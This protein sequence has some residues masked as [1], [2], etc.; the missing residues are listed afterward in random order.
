MSFFNFLF[1]KKK[2]TFKDESLNVVLS[3]AKAKQL[4]KRLVVLSHP[5][6]NPDNQELAT[7]LSSLV[8]Q[9]RYNYQALI[10]LE[11]RIVTEL[12]NK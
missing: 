2:K 9:N 6:R 7:E 12:L 1:R 3:I 4:H 8:N 10:E 5:D 11:K